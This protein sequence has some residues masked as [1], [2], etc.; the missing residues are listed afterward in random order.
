MAAAGLETWNLSII[1]TL[2]P[3]IAIISVY[4]IT[5]VIGNATVLV[6]YWKKM[7]SG[8][9]RF[10]VPILAFV[11]FLASLV[12]SAC[13]LIR[14][15]LNV[16]FFSDIMCKS[17]YFTICWI[18]SVSIFI[19]LAIAFDRY[20]MVCQIEKTPL[21]E[22]QK[23]IIVKTIVVITAIL[24]CPVFA[25]SGV[26]LLQTPSTY[27][28]TIQGS[29]CVFSKH[30]SPTFD[31]IHSLIVGCG[32]IGIF[33]YV[34]YVNLKISYVIFT[35]IRRSAKFVHP[36]KQAKIKENHSSEDINCAVKLGSH[37]KQHT[38]TERTNPTA[39][40][41][42]DNE[43]MSFNI[44]FQNTGI[45]SKKDCI[46]KRN[47]DSSSEIEQKEQPQN[48]L[49][50]TSRSRLNRNDN[51]HQEV[52]PLA[53]TRHQSISIHVMFIVMFLIMVLAY[54]PSLV[55]A[56]IVYNNL[57]DNSWW[58][59]KEE[60]DLKVNMFLLLKTTYL[61]S[62]AANPYIYS[63]FDKKFQAA[64]KGFVRC[65]HSVNQ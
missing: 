13:I 18:V 39:E 40:E 43:H 52:L 45:D 55:V 23:W 37:L 20:R 41:I 6:I 42:K 4:C 12:L 29:V 10:F 62:S 11:D 26:V 22:R 19:V 63:L 24:N 5:G 49:M 16:I 7:I 21:T 32:T 15:C 25:T 53:V 46:E 27:N 30:S 44:G 47:L 9:G 64:L 61:I 58:V 33:V 1:R 34:M 60:S 48:T 57:Q 31:V 28:S 65:Q 38:R 51:P 8:K 50:L 59:H 14:L 56:I 17:L 2:A 35:K 3:T 54:I 36:S